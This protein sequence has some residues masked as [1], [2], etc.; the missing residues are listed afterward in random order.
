MNVVTIAAPT[1]RAIAATLV[2]AAMVLSACATPMGAAPA[3]ATGGVLT[4]HAGMTLYTFDKDTAGSGKSACN[5]PCA[6]L[7][8]ALSASADAKA[9]GD[10]GVVTRDD[11]TRQWAYRGKPLYT[12]SRDAAAGERKGDGFNQVWSLAKP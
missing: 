9:G 2:G 8:P 4:T 6:G 12:F 5:G 11:G 7:W 10:Y 1:R 3:M